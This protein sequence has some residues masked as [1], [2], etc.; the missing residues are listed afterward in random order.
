MS[1]K[2]PTLMMRKAPWRHDPRSRKFS[3]DALFGTLA[4]AVFPK[5]LGRPL[6]PV[7]N[8][9]NSLRCTGYGTAVNG[10][11]I[12]GRRF[13][14]DWQAAKIGKLQGQ[15]V[16]LTGGDPNMAMR[17]ERDCGFL[18]I[19]DSPYLLAT[20]TMGQTSWQTFDPALDSIAIE[21][22]VAGFVTVD[23]TNDIF[24]NIRSALI[25]AYDPKTG[26]GA[27]VQAFGKWF[28]A[29][30]FPKDGIVPQTYDATQYSYHHY[31]F[32]DFCEIDGVEYLMV[33][34]SGG[35]NMGK[36]GFQYFPREVVNREFK[37]SGTLYPSGTTLKIVK[38]LTTDQINLAKQE[39]VLGMIE[40]MI[41]QAW[42]TLSEIYINRSQ[43]HAAED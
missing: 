11:Y 36:N 6:R 39:T 19:E 32:V 13:H 38:P 4:P 37:L 31:L 23:G 43:L 8:Q 15:T 10:G 21:T 35:V 33:Q 27:V 22:R 42:Y 28:P 5:T 18:P 7:E 14:P 26:L 25:Q 2:T 12:K 9:M 30:T 16:D 20:S 24:D 17:S 34:N 41:L 3:H 40:R 29:W 1:N